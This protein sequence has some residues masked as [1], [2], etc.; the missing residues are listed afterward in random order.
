MISEKDQQQYWVL[1]K[2][3]QYITVAKFVEAFQSFW[4]GNALSRE[5]SVQFDKSYNH[6]AVLSSS[7]YGVK[8]AE[9]LK[10]SFSWQMLLLKRNSFVHIFK[11]FQVKA[12]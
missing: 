8:K 5:L 12:L 11:F 3:Y 7:N 2:Q 10:I 9:L 6:P 4:L 1:D